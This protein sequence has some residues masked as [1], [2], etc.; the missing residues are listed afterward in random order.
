MDDRA[1]EGNP[2][3]NGCD[4]CGIGATGGACSACVFALFF[5]LVE[6]ASG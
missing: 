5:A 2:T 4:D 3:S 1:G 6:A